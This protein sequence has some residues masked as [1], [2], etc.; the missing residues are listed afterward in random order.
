MDSQLVYKAFTASDLRIDDDEQAVV[1]YVSTSAVDRDDEVMLAS[2]LD[3]NGYN[4]VV[5]W[6]H[7]HSLP[8]IGRNLWLKRDGN[9]GIVAKTAFATTQFAQDVYRLVREK[10][11]TSVSVG[12]NG[13][14]SESREPTPKERKQ[15]GWDK[16]RRVWTTWALLEYSFV[17]VPANADAVVLAVGKGLKVSG[18]TLRLMNIPTGLAARKIISPPPLTRHRTLIYSPR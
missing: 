5:L 13:A 12:F 14:V 10:V 7:N 6:D 15:D 16:V 17:N 8:G 3:K 18:D 9:V 1:S 2:G 11:V 4:G